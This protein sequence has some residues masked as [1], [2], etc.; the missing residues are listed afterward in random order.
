LAE[1]RIKAT[2]ARALVAKGID[3]VEAKRPAP[4]PKTPDC[5]SFGQAA[6]LFWQANQSRWRNT[7]VCNG[8][9]PFMERHAAAIWDRPIAAMD[10]LAV[11]GVVQPLWAGKNTT[12]RRLMH[13]IHQVCGYAKWMHW[14]EGDNPAEYRGNLEHACPKPANA[15]IRH[16]PALPLSQLPSFMARLEALPG[17]A[18]LAARFAILTCSRVSEAFLA[19]W[20]EI[21]LE[22]QTFRI[23]ANRYK[24]SKEH[25]VPLSA[26]AMQVL[27]ACPRF[28]GN[29]YVF[30]SPTKPG[31]SLSNMAGIVLLKRMGVQT[32][33]HGTARSTFA[34]WAADHTDADFETREGCLGHSVGSAVTRA[35][36]R[37][38]ALAKRRAL[39]E[40][41]GQT[42]TAAPATRIAAE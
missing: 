30:P 8:W 21:N 27:S 19:T 35:Y 15:N 4:T 11:L 6:E 2:E 33:L 10:H 37:G 20:D 34:D 26:P 40:L 36:R 24:T 17:V 28:A 41:W 5:P 31:A 23:P 14:R 16:H 39:L 42:L 13:R 9:L 18:A 12:A 3:P 22:A 29:P 7:K 25:V 38:D 32:T 1:A